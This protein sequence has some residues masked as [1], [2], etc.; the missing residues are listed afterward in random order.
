MGKYLNKCVS[1]GTEIRKPQLFMY[2]TNKDLY[3]PLESNASPNLDALSEEN[4][5]GFKLR[6]F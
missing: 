2:M 6:V 3:I 4:C 1:K 5:L